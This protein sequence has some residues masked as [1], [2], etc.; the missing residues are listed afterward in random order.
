MGQIVSSGWVVR[1]CLLAAAM[2]AW[3]L[4]CLACSGEVPPAAPPVDAAAGGGVAEESAVIQFEQ[5]LDVGLLPPPPADG[6]LRVTTLT[7][8]Y[9]VF[10]STLRGEQGLPSSTEVRAAIESSTDGMLAALARDATARGADLEALEAQ[11]RS[12]QQS[13]IAVSSLQVVGARDAAEAYARLI[14]HPYAIYT[15]NADSARVPPADGESA[16]IY[17]SGE[18]SDWHPAGGTLTWYKTGAHPGMLLTVWFDARGLQH[19]RDLTAAFEMQINVPRLHAGL[20]SQC[21][22]NTDWH[23]VS[24]TFP[25]GYRD[26]N[27]LVPLSPT[28]HWY[29]YGAGTSAARLMQPWTPYRVWVP[30]QDAW[31]APLDC[32]VREIRVFS[33]P[34]WRN[35]GPA[36]PLPE[37]PACHIFS[38]DYGIAN[39]DPTDNENAMLAFTPFDVDDGETIQWARNMCPIDRDLTG[40]IAPCLFLSE[41]SYAECRD[42]CTTPGNLCTALGQC[43]EAVVQRTSG[44]IFQLGRGFTRWGTARCISGSTW[45]SAPGTPAVEVA[46]DRPI[47]GDSEFVNLYVPQAQEGRY[48]LK[49][50]DVTTGVWSNQVTFEVRGA[51]GECTCSDGDQD[52]F[53]STACVDSD[54]WPRGDCNDSVAGM[55]PGRQETC[56]NG[57]DDDCSSATQDACSLACTPNHHRG[58]SAGDVYWYDSCGVR[59]ALDDDCASGEWC[60]TGGGGAACVADVCPQGTDYCA[61]AERRRCDGEGS[62]SS[63][64]EACSAQCGCGGGGGGDGGGGAGVEMLLNAGFESGSD[65]IFEWADGAWSGYDD[66]SRSGDE[67]HRMVGGAAEGTAFARCNLV[68]TPGLEWHVQLL[69]HGLRLENGHVYRAAFRARVSAGV[70]VLRAITQ[71]QNGG[72]RYGLDFP[73]TL[74]TSW[75]LFE[76]TFTASGIVGGV[77]TN[78]RFT[79][80]LSPTGAPVTIDLDA[81]SLRADDATCTSDAQCQADQYCS[82][83]GHCAADVCPQGTD[84]CAGGERRRCTANGVSSTSLEACAAACGCTGNAGAEMLVNPGFE[85]PADTIF[86]WGDGGW[87]G[88]REAGRVGDECHR[89]VGAAV[90]GTA[91]ARCNVTAVAGLEWHVQLLQAGLRLDNGRS[92]RLSFQARVVAGV[93]AIHLITQ[94]QDSG[95]RYGLDRVVMLTPSWTTFEVTFTA[96]G[97]AGGVDNNS[98][99]TFFLMPTDSAAT[100]DIDAVSL[101]PVL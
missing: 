88:Y 70:H 31:D 84:Y 3:L 32:V 91:F 76:V 94:K 29:N 28:D 42:S 90:E 83:G 47:D 49:C 24:T 60:S 15:A 62:S 65:V 44:R 16:R 17:N 5:P 58:C 99:F 81:V 43:A 23:T 96:S 85:N 56:N 34:S 93:R 37:D 10:S 54:C 21:Y 57:V 86:E 92:Y 38:R 61:S 13:P 45:E 101:R 68:G 36:F 19:Y 78:S 79:F 26:W 87:S 6:S 89:V 80:F 46:F 67:C 98:R 2:V 59:G 51:P 11:K 64:L 73:A 40:A 27:C 9:G 4:G 100:I 7:V 20:G 74:T 63:L 25:A 97:I 30:L 1:H 14:G 71:K 52:G 55:N 82:A 53:Y 8:A 12:A 39:G 77:D 69:Q 33:Q 18:E 48:R 41:D 95:D 66:P 75:Q 72:D 22:M 50:R 35:D